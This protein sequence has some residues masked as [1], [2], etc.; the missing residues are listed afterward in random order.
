MKADS[1]DAKELGPVY[2]GR[3]RYFR[4]AAGHPLVASL[5]KISFA[6]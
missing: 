3:G 5:L 1:F 6:K 2:R 4:E